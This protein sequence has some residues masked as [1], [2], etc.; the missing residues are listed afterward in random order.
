MIHELTHIK[1]GDLWVNLVQTIVQVVYFYNPFVWLANVIVRRIREQAVDEMVLVALGT[2]AKSYSNTLIDIAEMAFWKAN[3]SSAS[4]WR[5][6]IQ[7]VIRK[8]D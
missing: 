4:Y 5:S 6:R 1:R 3:F 7:K 2:E 8:K